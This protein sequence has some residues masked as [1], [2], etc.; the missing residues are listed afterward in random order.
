ML[1]VLDVPSNRCQKYSNTSLGAS[2]IATNN[3]AS[4]DGCVKVSGVT[5]YVGH[6]QTS[7]YTTK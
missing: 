5:S 1:G 6:W 3:T 4:A 7:W 2:E